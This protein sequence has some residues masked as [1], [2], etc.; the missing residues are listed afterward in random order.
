V[1]KETKR[2]NLKKESA[3][4]YATASGDDEKVLGIYLNW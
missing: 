2:S 4:L 1:N 3:E